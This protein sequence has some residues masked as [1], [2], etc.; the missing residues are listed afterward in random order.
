M[1][2]SS[3]VTFVNPALAVKSYLIPLSFSSIGTLDNPEGIDLGLNPE[4]F[5]FPISFKFYKCY[6]VNVSYIFVYG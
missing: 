2:P 5:P 6:F 3:Y 1:K 4:S